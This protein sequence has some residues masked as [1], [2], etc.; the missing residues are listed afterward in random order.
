M[1]KPGLANSWVM[2]IILINVFIYLLQMLTVDYV[3]FDRP[4]MTFFGALTPSLVIFKGY[5]WQ[6]VTYM[7]LHDV[8]SFFHLLFNMFILMMCGIPIEQAWGGKKFLIYY[9][10]TGIGAGICI[11]AMNYFT[12]NLYVST[13]GASGS[14]FGIL[15]AFGILYPDVE[16]L[17]FFIIPIKAKYMVVLYGIVEFVLTIMPSSDNISHIGH[18][19]GLIFGLIYFLFMRKHVILFKS[20]MIKAKLHID[21]PIKEKS[22]KVL[23]QSPKDFL[24][25][26]LNK[27]KS[28]GI[29]AITDDEFQKLKYLQIMNDNKKDLC[30]EEDFGVSDKHCEKCENYEPCLLREI[31]NFL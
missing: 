5:V 15:L 23:D 31:K 8:T 14:V 28:G 4:V 26:V 10:F 29:N 9:F 19:G 21:N 2:K 13:L 18:V 6:F 22:D 25:L 20:K 16:F 30:V 11:F 7:F 17:L 27:V 12:G 1:D 3:I 24:L